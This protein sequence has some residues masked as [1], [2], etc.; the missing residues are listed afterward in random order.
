MWTNFFGILTGSKSW[1]F[2]ALLGTLLVAALAVIF[3]LNVELDAEQAAHNATRERLS[4]CQL[5][6]AFTRE[7]LSQAKNATAALQDSLHAAQAREV[8]AR[9]D[10]SARKQI[11]S[12]SKPRPRTEV[13]RQ[14]VVDDATRNAA[15]DR[16][17]RDW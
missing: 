8:K 4:Y 12:G 5:D 17:N 7:A 3:A 6:A 13:E 14:E 9:A 2:L 10:A 16:L 15:A 11:L 1:P